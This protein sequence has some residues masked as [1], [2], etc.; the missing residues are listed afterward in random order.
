[1]T[2]KTYQ[3]AIYI[4][5]DLAEIKKL[6]R[7]FCFN[8]DPCIC[9]AVTPTEFIYSGVSETGAAVGFI[10]YPR[11]SRP[12]EIIWEY[13][14]SLAMNLMLKTFQRSCTIVATDKT[15]FYQNPNYQHKG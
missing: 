15:L 6:C 14:T 13:A 8:S 11:F 4:A 12:P 9:V 2:D 1:M 10:N 7:E 3:A 5:G